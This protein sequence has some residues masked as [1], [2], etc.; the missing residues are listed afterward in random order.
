MQP[1]DLVRAADFV[2]NYWYNRA[3]SDWESAKKLRTEADSLAQKGAQLNSS[4]LERLSEL[5][6]ILARS[7]VMFE[8]A[9]RVQ[10]LVRQHRSLGTTEGAQMADRAEM[11][12]EELNE[13]SKKADFLYHVSLEERAE[14][15][16]ENID[17]RRAYAFD[18]ERVLANRSIVDEFNSNLKR[19]I[20]LDGGDPEKIDLF[21]LL[22]DRTLGDADGGCAGAA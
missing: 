8:K 1:K 4:R 3:K 10:G 9:R 22:L 15:D 12:V 14:I 5:Q 6:G 16:N 20:L 2:A 11:R 7:L 13:W 19:E 18:C 21:A 17:V